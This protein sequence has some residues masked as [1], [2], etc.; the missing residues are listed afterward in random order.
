MGEVKGGS[1]GDVRYV[2]VRIVYVFVLVILVVLIASVIG[3]VAG[4][5]W[6]L[7]F[8][9]AGFAVIVAYVIYLAY[10]M[11]WRLAYPRYMRAWMRISPRACPQSEGQ[12]LPRPA[13]P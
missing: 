4:G 11:I 3:Q 6:G 9:L 12:P 7:L 8:T 2:A 10:I 5:G 1:R 13:A